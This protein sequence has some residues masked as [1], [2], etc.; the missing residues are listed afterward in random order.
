MTEQ[1]QPTSVEPA[2]R[3]RLLGLLGLASVTACLVPMLSATSAEAA[4][5][6]TGLAATSGTCQ[7]SLLPVPDG[8]WRSAVNAGDPTGRY[9]LGDAAVSV[10]GNTTTEQL[11]WVNGK[12]TPFQTPYTNATLVDVSQHGA[13]TGHAQRTDGWS[14]AWRYEHGRF[15]TLPGLLPGDVT[16]P[17]AINARG[18]V[19]G[20][21]LTD[22]MG[23]SVWHA[24]IWPANR[25]GT[26]RELN[27]P[28]ATG[29]A[30]AIDIDDDGTILGHIGQN[31]GAT[32]Y[33]WPPNG[34]PRQLPAPAGT[35][36]AVGSAIRNGWVA[37]SA[38]DG[39]HSVPVRWN[40]RTG[41]VLQL[42]TDFL[43]GDAVN[44][45]GAVSLGQSIAHR[46]GSI[47]ALPGLTASDA[48]VARVLTDRG[49]AAGFDNDGTVHAVTWTAC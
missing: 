6:E 2:T 5:T 3:R 12:L 19:V 37:G 22:P 15:G 13:I 44:R 9:L 49:T 46:D 47:V 35:T 7:I 21:S 17:A 48:R 43:T 14:F 45:H 20:Y 26:V 39:Q 41:S 30:A 28:G 11:L 31:P 24:V 33:V 42:S 27:V 23:S 34:A 4:V 16:E 29:P 8:T 10:N 40:L 38:F 18:D 1:Q 25:P 32:Y 36:E